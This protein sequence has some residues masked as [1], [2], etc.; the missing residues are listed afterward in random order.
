MVEWGS[1]RMESLRHNQLVCF[2]ENQRDE[3]RILGNKAASI[4]ATSG[5]HQTNYVSYLSSPP[6]INTVK[7][8]CFRKCAHPQT[9]DKPQ[10]WEVT[11]IADTLNVF[12]NTEL[13][14][15]LVICFEPGIAK[16]DGGQQICE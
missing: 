13:R 9:T 16:R 3:I 12:D 1:L 2:T 10:R 5:T 4:S 14:T 6:T 8:Q 7:H 11:D 15:P